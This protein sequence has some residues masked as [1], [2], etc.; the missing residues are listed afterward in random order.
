MSKRKDSDSNETST[1][2]RELSEAE[3]FV[4]QF[5]DIAVNLIVLLAF[6]GLIAAFFRTSSV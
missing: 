4:S 1:T 2:E 6:A 3:S 5:G